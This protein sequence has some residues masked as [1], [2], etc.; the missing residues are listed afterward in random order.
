M[1]DSNEILLTINRR[2]FFEEVFSNGSSQKVFF[3]INF[4]WILI[5]PIHFASS[6][7]KITN[8]DNE[9]KVL[10]DYSYLEK[11]ISI[12][13]EHKVK[14]HFQH[15]QSSTQVVFGKIEIFFKNGTRF[16]Y[17]FILISSIFIS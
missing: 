14:V 16:T 12:L 4:G 11:K 1:N 15:L 17:N 13:N 10:S 5:H 6:A 8:K 3:R 2:G 9:I 7:Y